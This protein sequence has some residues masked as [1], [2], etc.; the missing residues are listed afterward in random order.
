MGHASA[1]GSYRGSFVCGA[2]A[3]GLDGVWLLEPVNFSSHR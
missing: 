2:L 1:H 3:P